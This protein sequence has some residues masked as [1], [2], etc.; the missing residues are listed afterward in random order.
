[1]NELLKILQ[2]LISYPSVTPRDE[3]VMQFLA[4]VLDSMGFE[5][6]IVDFGEG[7]SKAEVRV[8]NLYAKIGTG[9][10]NLCFAGHV[11]VVPAGDIDDWTHHP[12]SGDI[13][14]GVIYGRGAVD[15]KG[16]IAAYIIAV[17]KFLKELSS[18]KLGEGEF[19]R[20]TTLSFLITGDEEGLARNGTAKMLRWLYER[21]ER[22]G[23]CIIGEPV[24]NKNVGDRI[25]IGA[26]G[27]ITMF[28]EVKGTQ[29]HVADRLSDNPITK[30]IKVMQQINLYEFDAGS[31]FFEHTNLEFTNLE[32]GNIAENVIPGKARAQLNVRFND[33]YTA[34]DICHIVD[35]IMASVLRRDEYT[36]TYQTSGEA[37]RMEEGNIFLRRLKISIQS[38]TQ[39]TPIMNTYGATSDARFIKDYCPVAEIGLLSEM[40]HKVNECCCIND[41]NILSGIY[42][43]ILRSLIT[44]RDIIVI[45]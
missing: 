31:D 13:E 19:W 20:N 23:A 45:Q 39:I 38:V 22:L 12:F 37:F 9:D 3:G 2:Q 36:L 34:V 27:S 7:E 16:A 6:Q 18:D 11:D 8:K 40:A 28:L 35:E 1:M 41:L 44:V 15:M 17:D 4:S 43:V 29:G 32:V 42:Q 33:T 21:G 24:S 30:L 5:C 26:R 25:K 10:F 14:K